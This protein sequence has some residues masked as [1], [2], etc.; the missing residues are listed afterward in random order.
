[1]G[2]SYSDEMNFKKL[3][4]DYLIKKPFWNM[5]VEESCLMGKSKNNKPDDTGTEESCWTGFDLVVSSCHD[6]YG[7]IDSDFTDLL[8]NQ[9]GTI[10]WKPYIS[11]I[12]DKF[13]DD[14][15][16]VSEKLKKPMSLNSKSTTDLQVS[17]IVEEAQKLGAVY[18][19]S[20]FNQFVPYQICDYEM[21]NIIMYQMI[22]QNAKLIHEN[23]N[24][25]EEYQKLRQQYRDR[26]ET[27]T[28]MNILLWIML[29]FNLTFAVYYSMI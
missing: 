10:Q 18:I 4:E 13:C 16:F 12:C 7:R 23:L 22:D 14:S 20:A 24:K 15:W 8:Q 27:K 29:S 3:V 6:N 19:P 1:M 9:Y 25:N 17:P 28:M 21:N 26:L 5:I 2:S 11:G